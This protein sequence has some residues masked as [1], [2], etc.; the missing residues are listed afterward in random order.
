[1][2]AGNGLSRIPRIK[3]NGT[4]N[5]GNGAFGNMWRKGRMFS[6][7]RIWKKWHRKINS[8]LKK[9]AIISA[10]SSSII[11]SLIMA[12]GHKILNVP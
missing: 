12:R 7:I 9:L 10:L 8:N 6:P 11:P 3:I 1:M 4:T 2:H 5:S